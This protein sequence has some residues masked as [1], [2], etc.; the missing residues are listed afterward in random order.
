MQHVNHPHTE[1]S[2]LFFQQFFDRVVPEAQVGGIF[3]PRAALREG[4]EITIVDGR[5]SVVLVERAVGDIGDLKV[6]N[7]GA[8]DRID[9]RDQSTG[10]LSVFRRD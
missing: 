9:C 3:E 1:N 5:G 8:V 2:H 4:N 7:F 10:R 6:R